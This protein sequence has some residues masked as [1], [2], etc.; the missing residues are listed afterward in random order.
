MV[1][2]GSCEQWVGITHTIKQTILM[3]SEQHPPPFQLLSKL[4]LWTS[5]SHE[6]RLLQMS[7]RS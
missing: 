1:T 6:E 3:L 2:N 7:H 5:G 4:V